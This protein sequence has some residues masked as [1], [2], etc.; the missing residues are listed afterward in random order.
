MIT[1]IPTGVDFF[2]EAYGGTYQGRVMLVTAKSGAGKTILGVQFLAEGL[3]RGERCLLLSARP[4]ED[5]ALHASGFGLPVDT[6]IAS[7]DLII[8][9]YSEFVPGRDREDTLKLPPD[10]FLQL[11]QIIEEQSVQRVVLDTILPWVALKDEESLAEHI[12]S[13]VRVFHRIGTT[14]LFTLPKPASPAANRL[15]KLLEDVVPVSVTLHH[16]EEENRY[17]WQVNKY[18]GAEQ[19]PMTVPYE[20]KSKVGLVRKG[21]SA[22]PISPAASAPSFAAAQQAPVRGP[23]QPQTPPRPASQSGGKP[24]FSD[25]LLRSSSGQQQITPSTAHASMASGS[26]WGS[27]LSPGSKDQR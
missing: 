19:S 24:S 4:A 3:K 20:I 12:F 9:E 14:S 16:Y 7:N 15:R 8:L 10:S 1:K 13:F 11:K 2:D 21:A 5:V 22:K 23:A 17:E 18:L 25:L 6:A 26:G 27:L